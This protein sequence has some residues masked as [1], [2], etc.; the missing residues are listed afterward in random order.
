MDYPKGTGGD[1]GAAAI[2]HG[3]L[4]EHAIKLG[5]ND[6]SGRAHLQTGGVHTVLTDVRHHEPAQIA[7]VWAV[8]LLDE[9]DM[10][11]VHVR[12]RPRIVIRITGNRQ[13]LPRSGG[14]RL[15]RQLCWEAVPLVTRHLAGL[16]ANAHRGIGVKS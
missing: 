1:T 7:A 15:L 6:R 3:G 5:A 10:P 12:E 8:A 2:A 16:T 9:L 4:N 14:T 11:P 13:R